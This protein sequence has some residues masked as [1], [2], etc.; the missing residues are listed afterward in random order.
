MNNV[1]FQSNSDEWRTPLS[2]FQRINQLFFFQY[3]AASTLDNSLCPYRL[4]DGLA[5][6]WPNLTFCNPIFE[7]ILIFSSGAFRNLEITF[8]NPNS[9]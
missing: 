4:N 8:F 3:D 9:L 1:L 7:F 5:E 6:L 2:F